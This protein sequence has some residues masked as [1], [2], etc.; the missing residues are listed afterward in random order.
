MIKYST[1]KEVQNAWQDTPEAH[2]DIHET[3]KE[4]VNEHIRMNE[5]RTFVENHIF[6]FGERSFHWLWYLIIQEMP[7][8]FSFL[9]IG[10]LKGQTLS[11]VEMLANEMGK[12]AKCY[13]VTPLS[14][15]GGVWESDY[16]ADIEFIH[17]KFGLAKDYTILNGLSEDPEIIKKASKL[18]LDILY[19]DGGHSKEHVINDLQHYS[20]LVKLGGYMVIDDACNS[21]RMPFGY[22]QGIEAVTR[23]VDDL[24]P[25]R[26][27]HPEWEFICSVVHNRV[28]QKVK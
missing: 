2:S 19:V 14:T 24:L 15:E 25:P 11:L 16:K 7:A 17:D 13:G 4:K 21:F 23:V 22:F 3:F 5:H 9:E 18:K 6:G 8:K 12:K 28:Y 20:P 27:P 10:V 1:L 26:T